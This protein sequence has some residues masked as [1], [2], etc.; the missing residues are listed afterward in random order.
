MRTDE[1]FLAR[2]GVCPPYWIYELKASF[3]SVVGGCAS[4]EDLWN[5]LREPV[6]ATVLNSAL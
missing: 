3:L 4:S 1:G 2:P 6:G 5:A